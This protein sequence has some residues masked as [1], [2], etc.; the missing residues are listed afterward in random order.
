M[1]WHSLDRY[2]VRPT[3][4]T[5]SPYRNNLKPTSITRIVRLLIQTARHQQPYQ[6]DQSWAVAQIC[7]YW[8]TIMRG[9][10]EADYFQSQI[11]DGAS[12]LR[13]EDRSGGPH[14]LPKCMKAPSIIIPP[15]I[16][17]WKAIGLAFPTSKYVSLSGQQTGAGL[18]SHWPRGEAADSSSH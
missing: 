16:F 13:T 4:S 7:D 8:S 2:I 15:T 10:M 11:G 14:Y 5:T 3:P 12:F 17:A 6:S 9:L 1:A 18:F